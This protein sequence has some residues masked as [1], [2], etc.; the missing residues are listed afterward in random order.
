MRQLR[1]IP[2]VRRRRRGCICHK[3]LAMLH[4]ELHKPLHWLHQRRTVHRRRSGIRDGR[5]R[6]RHHQRQEPIQITRMRV[7]PLIED[8]IWPV[9]EELMVRRAL[10]QPRDLQ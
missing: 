9:L 4:K 6:R 1:C 3:P 5:G 10:Q 2:L 8:H 7:H